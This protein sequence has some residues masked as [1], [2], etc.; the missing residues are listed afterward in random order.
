[1]AKVVVLF[2]NKVIKE[3]AIG[4]QGLKIGRDPDNDIQI[5]NIAVSRHHAEIYRQGYPYYVEDMK[6]TN[7]ITLNGSVLS[8]KSGLNNN[9]KVTIGKHTLVFVE[10]EKDNLDKKPQLDVNETLCL[11]PEDL[12]RLRE[13]S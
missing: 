2:K 10:E 7:G 4:P 1:M 6:S 11:S 3:V 9:D 13:K 5:D 12:A 8:W